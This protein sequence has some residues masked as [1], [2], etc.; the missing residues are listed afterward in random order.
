M[1]NKNSKRIRKILSKEGSV[2][3]EIP[4]ANYHNNVRGTWQTRRISKV[5][6]V[7]KPKRS[8][9]PQ[10]NKEQDMSLTAQRAMLYGK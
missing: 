4:S 6:Y 1:A 2:N 8:P 10:P 5:K 9:F 7:H 3:I